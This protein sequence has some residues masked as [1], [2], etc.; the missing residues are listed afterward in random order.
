MESGRGI[1]LAF[2]P[3][4][5]GPALATAR[6]LIP[7]CLGVTFAI[8]GHQQPRLADDNSFARKA[9]EIAGVSWRGWNVSR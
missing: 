6:E 1:S 4:A 3:R 2:L 5:G 9:L 7:A 8:G